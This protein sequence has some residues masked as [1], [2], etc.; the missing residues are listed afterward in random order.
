[1]LGKFAGRKKGILKIQYS[2][3]RFIP[4]EYQSLVFYGKRDRN[5]GKS[6]KSEQ[7]FRDKFDIFSVSSMNTLLSILKVTDAKRDFALAVGL[8]HRFP[9]RHLPPTRDYQYFSGA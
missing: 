6:K 8:N 9:W 2:T 5:N 7:Y 1:M 4:K 3:G